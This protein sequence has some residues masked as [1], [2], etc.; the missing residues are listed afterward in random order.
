MV[1]SFFLLFWYAKFSVF[2]MAVLWLATK[3]QMPSNDYKCLGARRSLT[4]CARRSL[5]TCLVPSAFLNIDELKIYYSLAVSCCLS[6]LGLPC[7]FAI[8]RCY[9]GPEL[10]VDLL[11]YD[12]S[13]DLWSLG[14]MFAAMVSGKNMINYLSW[15]TD[16]CWCAIWY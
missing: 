8:Y 12:Y 16:L 14:C 4:T 7:P 1:I 15:L 2:S 6:P 10:L 11:D 3:E 13:L 9:K 5:T